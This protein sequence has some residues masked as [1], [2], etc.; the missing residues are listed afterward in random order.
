MIAADS[1]TFKHFLP[2][3][4]SNIETH[5]FQYKTKKASKKQPEQKA[6]AKKKSEPCHLGPIRLSKTI[7]GSIVWWART[8]GGERP[9][10]FVEVSQLNGNLWFQLIHPKTEIGLKNRH[11]LNTRKPSRI[12]AVFVDKNGQSDP[13]WI[14]LKREALIP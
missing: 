1:K 4:Y 14:G 9:L 8:D 13:V 3:S 6:A 2:F 5:K 7:I 12:A 10:G 11:L